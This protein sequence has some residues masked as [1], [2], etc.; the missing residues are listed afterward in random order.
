MLADDQHIV[1][2]N[3]EAHSSFQTNILHNSSLFIGKRKISYVWIKLISAYD[4]DIITLQNVRP[5]YKCYSL[6][7]VGK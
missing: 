6:S 4:K 3:N 1:L 7:V 2:I 5:S